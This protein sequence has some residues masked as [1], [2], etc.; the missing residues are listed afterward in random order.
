MIE[1]EYNLLDE[2]W[3]KVL[4]DDGQ[5]ENVSLK[6]LFAM[7]DRCRSLAGELP[8]QDLAIMRLVIAVLY[9]IYCEEDIEGNVGEIE[10]EDDA[11]RRWG[12]IWGRGRFDD[13]RIS[14]YL[15]KYR[16]RFYLIHPERPFYQALI[17]EG[18]SYEASKMN[19]EV[20]ESGNKVRLFSAISPG[21][22]KNMEYDEAARWIINLMNFDDTAL[23]AKGKNLPSVSTGWLGVIGP[24][25]LEGKNLFET[26][27]LNLVLTDDNDQP[28]EVKHP[29]W[30][31]DDPDFRERVIIP[32]PTTPVQ[33][34]T[35]Q[36]RRIKLLI[37]D[38]KV[39]G[40]MV[41]G[42]DI[43][44]K[45]G[46]FAET[47]TSWRK[48]SD[49]SWLP[50]KVNPSKALWRDFQA[51][52]VK[53][54]SMSSYR[55]P[56]VIRWMSRLPEE[57]IEKDAVRI[58]SVGA[59]YDS[60]SSSITNYVNDGLDVNRRLLYGIGDRWVYRITKCVEYTEKCVWFFKKFT[61]NVL[62]AEGCDNLTASKQA[63]P[64]EEGCYYLLDQPFRRWL[65]SIDPSVDD[66]DVTVNRWL[67]E[68]ERIILGCGKGLL[69]ESNNRA[70]TCGDDGQSVFEMFNKFQRE[71]RSITRGD[72]K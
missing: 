67:L 20:A 24:V 59:T 36:S 30:E 63:V 26:L 61:E 25:Y 35:L 54:D 41:M 31:C 13:V 38:S 51:I 9:A 69:M 15:E 57:M 18:T 53:S 33:L 48:A 39:T 68:V 3:V 49:G 16:E 62:K 71:V 70:I 6:E 34:M 19:G 58:R 27:V 40:C 60:Q 11:Y 28:F 42:G 32:D 29:S 56:G 66:P 47:M 17:E 1:K 37:Q 45:K 12:G 46:V 44:S 72:M 21:T 7:A 5:I 65:S 43:I 2:R 10:D 52:I 64:H 23:K 55:R 50:R 22:K 4:R 14:A 8:T